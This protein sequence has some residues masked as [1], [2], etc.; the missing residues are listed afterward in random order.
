V[1]S[2][3]VELVCD[4]C[5]A[6]GVLRVRPGTLYIGVHAQ[7]GGLLRAKASNV[8]DAVNGTIRERAQGGQHG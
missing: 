5:G 6:V 7:C 3:R 1:S 2:E 8:T 4:R